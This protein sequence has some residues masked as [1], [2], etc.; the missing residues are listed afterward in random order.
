MPE[1][2]IEERDIAVGDEDICEIRQIPQGA[3]IQTGN[4]G[5]AAERDHQEAEDT[6]QHD[7]AP[8]LR[9]SVRADLCEGEE[10]EKRGEGKEAEADRNQ[11]GDHAV[12]AL[13][14][15]ELRRRGHKLRELSELEP[16]GGLIGQPDS[17]HDDDKARQGAD[18]D[19]VQEDAD[20]LHAALIAGVGRIAG[21]GRHGDRTLTGLITHESAPHALRERRSEGAAEDCLR[22]EGLREYRVEEPGNAVQIKE[23][24]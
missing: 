15:G 10:A 22:A 1:A 7:E 11:E 2:Q 12:E 9:D 14:R 16:G 6:D 24:K 5:H 8:P 17:S 18:H 13:S 20:R 4:A 19:G 23:Q 21:C 3:E